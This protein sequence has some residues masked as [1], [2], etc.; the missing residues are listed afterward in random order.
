MVSKQ[1]GISD[2]IKQY[3]YMMALQRGLDVNVTGSTGTKASI[4]IAG[5][6]FILP[7]QRR[8]ASDDSTVDYLLV[9]RGRVSLAFMTT[10][11][12]DD[13]QSAEMQNDDRAVMPKHILLYELDAEQAI[14][15]Y[16][17]AVPGRDTRLRYLHG[18]FAGQGTDSMQQ[19]RIKP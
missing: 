5:N 4:T 18:M 16:L 8:L 13:K 6:A 11:T 9:L 14:R 2:L 7:A 3:F 1:P 15:M 17:H 12:S 10:T 19:H